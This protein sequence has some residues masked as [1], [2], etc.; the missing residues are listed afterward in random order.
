[1][2]ATMPKPAAAAGPAGHLDLPAL[3]MLPVVMTV[4]HFAYGCGFLVGLLKSARAQSGGPPAVSMFT[5]LT[6]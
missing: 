4:Y 5:E 6:R 3:L 1:M 2:I